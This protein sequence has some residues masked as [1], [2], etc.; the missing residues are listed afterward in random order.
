MQNNNVP[1]KERIKHKDT[2]DLLSFASHIEE[3]DFKPDCTQHTLR[4][5]PRSR[6]A[7]Q[8]FDPKVSFVLATGQQMPPPSAPL[9]AQGS[10][11]SHQPHARFSEDRLSEESRAPGRALPSAQSSRSLQQQPQRCQLQSK[12]L[13]P[14]FIPCDKCFYLAC[15]SWVPQL[16]GAEQSQGG[17]GLA[18]ARA[19]PVTHILG[20]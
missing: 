11:S 7:L 3:P 4:Q 19:L 15:S 8:G 13:F 6:A 14:D 20:Q 2:G 17:S 5:E 10:P 12:S 18:W 16:R 9:R 1:L